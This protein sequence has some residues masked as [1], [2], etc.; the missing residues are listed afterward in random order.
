MQRNYLVVTIFVA[1]I[2]AAFIFF[3]V[4]YEIN[5]APEHVTLWMDNETTKLGSTGEI[6][7]FDTSTQ[8]VDEGVYPV[9]EVWSNESVMLATLFTLTSGG[10]TETFSITD[11]PAQCFLPSSGTW[12]AHINGTASGE[13][14]VNVNADFYYMLLMEPD[15]ITYYPYKYFG[16][17]M[18]AVGILA[19]LVIYLKTSRENA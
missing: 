12:S 14:T 9:I 17:G 2:G 16:Y 19:S 15:H 5:L 6:F 7:S 11:N 1:V 8:V 10:N 4:T 3:P 13:D 18:F